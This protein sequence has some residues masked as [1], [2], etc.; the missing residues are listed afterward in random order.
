MGRRVVITGL[1]MVSP[2]GNDVQTSWSRLLAGDSGAAD[3]KLDARARASLASGTVLAV[4]VEPP[5]G[6]TT[7]APTGD[8]VALGPVTAI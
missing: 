1:G 6:S 2:L 3:V 7:G 5:G 4:S 8:V